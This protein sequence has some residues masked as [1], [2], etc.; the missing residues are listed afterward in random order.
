MIETYYA[1]VRARDTQAYKTKNA[2]FRKNH[3]DVR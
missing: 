1:R 2:I 3:V